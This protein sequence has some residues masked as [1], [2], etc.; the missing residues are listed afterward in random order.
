V[1]DLLPGCGGQQYY[2]DGHDDRKNSGEAFVAVGNV[3]IQFHSNS[4]YLFLV[5]DPA[6][7]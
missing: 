5:D 1:V 2:H 6:S 7:L 3:V 4:P